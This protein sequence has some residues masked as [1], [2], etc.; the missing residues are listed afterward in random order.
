MMRSDQ[1][2]EHLDAIAD[3]LEIKGESPFRVNAY[4]DVARR[5]AHH[6]EEIS[7]LAEEQR[8]RSIPGVGETLAARIVELIQ[9][10]TTETYE[11]LAR[12][13]PAGLRDLLAVPGLGPKRVRQLYDQLSIASLPDLEAAVQAGRLRAVPGFGAKTEERM[14]RDLARLRQRVRRHLLGEAWPLAEEIAAALRALRLAERVEVAGSIRRRLET[15]GDLDI[16][17]ASARPEAFAARAVALPVVEQVQEHGPTKLTLLTQRDVQLDIRVVAP[18]EFGSALL[19]FTGSKQHNIHLRAMAQERGWKVNEYGLFDEATGARLAGLTEE[20]MYAR[21]GLAWIPP[22]LREDAGEI[23]AAAAGRL[24][25]L[26]TEADVR[27]ELHA[28]TDWSDGGASLEAMAE[29]ARARGY[30]YLAITDHSRSRAVAGGLS[31]E[32]VREQRAAIAAL[33]ARYAPFSI[34]AGSEVDIRADGTLDY[35]DE[36]LAAF[37]FVVASVHSGFAQSRDVMTQRLLNALAHPAVDVL[38][39]P[40]GRLI[41]KREGYELDVEAVIAAAARHG[42]AL[43]INSQPDRLDVRDTVARRAHE[44]GVLLCV[45]TDAHSPRHYAAL[46]FGIGQARRAWLPAEAVINTW[47]LER[48]L[49]WRRRR[50]DVL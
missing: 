49:T 33:K 16:V 28:H 50:L 30:A 2:A 48:L 1:V 26:I 39:H 43:E 35:D 44:A 38:G 17:I 36:T 4:R 15:I 8:L 42:K 10:G 11:E 13:M 19:H 27:G 23:E 41:G 32:R 34:L 24:P 12:S 20:E 25:T 21:L 29:A 45:A 18:H 7:I 14:L 3:L 37:D 5:I 9:R 31:V 22:E 46:R 47:P 40:S 6:P